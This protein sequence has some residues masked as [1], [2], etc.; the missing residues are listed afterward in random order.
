M[1]LQSSG[2][3]SIGDVQTE[4]GGSN[5]ASLSEYYRDGAYVTS[6]N[7]TVPTSGVIDLQDFYSTVK[8]IELTISSNTSNYNIL[9]AAT[10]V[11]Y[12][13]ATDSTPITL[14]IDS[15]VT[16]SGSGTSAIVSGALNLNSNLTITNNGTIAGYTG[17]AGTTSSAL[18]GTGGVGGTGG[19][20][21]YIDTNTGGSATLA[22]TN[23]GTINSGGGGGG[24]GGGPGR[25]QDGSDDGKG[26]ITCSGSF[27]TGSSGAAG[28][29]GG[30]AA[31]GAA[32]AA[33]SF[34]GGHSGCVSHAVG[35]G[36][37]GGNAG[38]AVRKNTRTVTVTNNATINGTVG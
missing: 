20:A 3:I 1:A 15:G 14:T 33:G 5:P 7:T 9:T 38:Y 30:A 31:G 22:I 18:T 29:A 10:A 36:G 28:A 34:G 11:G 17:A 26:N 12:N 4:F 2:A 21:I 16:V 27:Y 24:G 32:G 13:S 8:Q 19:D 6:N 25:R 23:N 35:A 37:A